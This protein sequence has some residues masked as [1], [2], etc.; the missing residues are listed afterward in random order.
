[1]FKTTDAGRT[2][3]KLEYPEYILALAIA[4]LDSQV[5]FA[6]TA[7]GIFQS[8]D[9]GK[10]WIQLDQYK[11][12]A[13]PAL[14]FDEDGIL[15]ASNK[16]GLS[17]SSDFGATWNKIN[18]PELTITSVS[19]DSQNKFMYVAGHSSGGSQEVYKSIDDGST[20]QL[21]GSNK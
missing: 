19:V 12:T 10:N 3:E 8:S 2:W 14:S 11:G 9:G 1:L 17:R 13:I 4:P 18:T 15:Y 7:D 16:F 6:G 20:W 21:I 5:V